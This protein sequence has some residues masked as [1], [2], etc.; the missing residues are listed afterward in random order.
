MKTPHAVLNFTQQSWYGAVRELQRLQAAFATISTALGV[1][2]A[3]A[4]ELRLEAAQLTI[5]TSAALATRLRHI[6]PELLAKLT[7][8]GWLI[9]R[10]QIAVVRHAQGLA[11]H[12]AAA[13]W[14]GI[15][16]LRYGPRIPPSA[17]QRAALLSRIK[18]RR[19]ARLT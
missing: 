17:E 5:K 1:P 16:E 3:Q 9:E 10:I 6:E 12:L 2:Q 18:Q 14:T 8:E 11:S 4:C 15:N 13:P 19:V 7:A